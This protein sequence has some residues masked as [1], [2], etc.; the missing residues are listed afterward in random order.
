MNALKLRLNTTFKGVTV[1]K[2]EMLE[3]FAKLEKHPHIANRIKELFNIVDNTSGKLDR[4]DD[5]E[6]Y[7]IVEIQK[8]SNELL[9]TWAVTQEEKKAKESRSSN[10]ELITHS[11][12]NCT[13]KQ[14]SG[15]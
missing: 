11:K 12:K 15:K 1:S 2:V 8:I 14:H 4:A 9:Q 7:L 13:G 3:L 5:A 10:K 6:E